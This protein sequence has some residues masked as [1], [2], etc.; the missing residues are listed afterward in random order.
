[1][2]LARR[3]EP[4][5]AR[6]VVQGFVSAPGRSSA[7]QHSCINMRTASGASGCGAAASPHPDTG[8]HFC[9]IS[10]CMRLLHPAMG[11]PAAATPGAGCISSISLTMLTRSSTFTTP[12]LPGNARPCAWRPRGCVTYVERARI[13]HAHLCAAGLHSRHCANQGPP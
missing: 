7:A 4:G 2:A 12:A 1:M 10:S 8:R 13:L 9:S 5:V 11:L 3:C 6:R